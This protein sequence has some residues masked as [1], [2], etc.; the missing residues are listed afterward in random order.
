ME[1]KIKIR[2]GRERIRYTCAFEVFLLA[3]LAPIGAY[4]FERSLTDI[5]L[6]S[7]ILSLKAM[8]INYLYNWF[9]DLLDLRA[10]KIPTERSFMRRIIHAIGFEIA[11]TLTSL[12]IVTWWLGL[13]ILEAL[14][15]DAVVMSFVVVYTFLFTLG[16]DRLY[17]VEQCALVPRQ[18]N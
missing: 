16:Y 7:V 1:Q 6:L 12:P 14:L 2:T 11:L 9:F 17:P 18:T 15:I 13:T 3:L 8:V 4:V 5:G 10:G